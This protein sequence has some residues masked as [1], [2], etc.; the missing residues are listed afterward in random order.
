MRF[1][2]PWQDATKHKI[3]VRGACFM[4]QQ[5]IN[6]YPIS[7]LACGSCTM[8][9]GGLMGNVLACPDARGR[10]YSCGNTRPNTDFWTKIPKSGRGGVLGC[11][12]KV[13]GHMPWGKWLGTCPGVPWVGPPWCGVTSGCFGEAV[14]VSVPQH[15]IATD[16]YTYIHIHAYTYIYLHV[17]TNQNLKHPY[18]GNQWSVWHEPKNR[19]INHQ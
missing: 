1:L 9:V 13:V 12:Q 2:R 3:V 19:T 7:A 6:T 14:V 5:A 15:A 8:L 17:P 10:F 11:G 16:T 4:H 18:L